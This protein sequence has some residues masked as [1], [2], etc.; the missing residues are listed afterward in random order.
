MKLC[1]YL[2]ASGALFNVTALDQEKTYMCYIGC[3]FNKPCKHN[4]HILLKCTACKNVMPKLMQ[5]YS[6]SMNH[7]L[8][9]VYGYVDI[10][11]PD[12]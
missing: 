7:V 3:L 2:Q 6:E 1:S 11:I 9:D 4:A 10:F 12:R 8:V 5:N